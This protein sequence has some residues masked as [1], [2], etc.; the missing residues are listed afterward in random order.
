MPLTE[1]APTTEGHDAS[2]TAEEST[3]GERR[4]LI[5]IAA[6]VL[7]VCGGLVTYGILDTEDDPKRPVL[8]TAEVTYEVRGEGTVEISYLA[9]GESGDATVETGVRPPWKKT[10]RVP[11]GKNPTVNIVLDAKGGMAGCTLAV[12][13]EHVQRATASGAYGRATC[14]GELPTPVATEESTG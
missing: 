8:P 2:E 10:V 6:V 5:G 14:T 7:L 3:A 1:T 9:G 12:R 11:L 4:A 13:G